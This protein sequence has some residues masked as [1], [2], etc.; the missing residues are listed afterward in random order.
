[1]KKIL[2]AVAA[3]VASVPLFAAEQVSTISFNPSRLGKFT[4]LKVNKQANLAGGLSTKNLI[5]A[6]SNG[7]NINISGDSASTRIMEIK[8]VTTAS[9]ADNV[10]VDMPN[11]YFQKLNTGSAAEKNY[12]LG[13]ALT[14]NQQNNLMNTVDMYGG[15]LE[16]DGGL[17]SSS[18]IGTIDNQSGSLVM[19][20]GTVYHEGKVTISGD[21]DSGGC[22]VQDVAGCHQ[23]L[24]LGTIT[25]PQPSGSATKF[26]WKTLK[27]YNGQLKVFVYE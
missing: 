14:A 10:V 20:A 13:S 7:G 26:G 5:L 6:A 4:Y 17:D 21:H 1:M 23:G 25:I 3:V 2:L 12:T 27:G 9:G 22:G 15:S 8:E 11:T 16:M 19:N 18:Y 24:T